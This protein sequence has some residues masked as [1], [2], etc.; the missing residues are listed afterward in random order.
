[1]EDTMA[2]PV[3]TAAP[4][5]L[6]ADDPYLLEAAC[7]LYDALDTIRISRAHEVDA[8]L[9]DMCLRVVDAMGVLFTTR[10]IMTIGGNR[11]LHTR[12]LAERYGGTR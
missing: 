10:L 9:A 4:A 1:M 2:H 7:D 12:L 5:A 3:R 6:L 8:I 11:A